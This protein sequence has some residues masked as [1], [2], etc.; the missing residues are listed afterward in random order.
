MDSLPPSARP[1]LVIRAVALH[2]HTVTT[3][4][5]RAAQ[6]LDAFLVALRA[7]WRGE[8]RSFVETQ[9]GDWTIVSVR[10]DAGV[11][12]VQARAFGSGTEGL[13]SRWRPDPV[14]PQAGASPAEGPADGAAS[15][16][17]PGR[18]APAFDDWLPPGARIVRRVVHHDAGRDAATLVA[19]AA[20]TPADAARRLEGGARRSGFRADPALPAAA[21]VPAG[22]GD[23]PGAP[24][25]VPVAPGRAFAFQRRGEEV[26]ATVAPHPEGAAVVL[27]WSAPR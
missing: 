24:D 25:A 3:H 6:P 2:G 14:A 19:L 1:E 17:S 26:V 22:S 4:R 9:R 23:P 15:P 12:T 13:S 11:R 27:H 8:G 10:D 5:F 18:A 7:R 16:G 20:I 21:A